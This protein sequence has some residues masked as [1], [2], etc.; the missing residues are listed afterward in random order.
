MK[1]LVGQPG[2]SL[3]SVSTVWGVR[4]GSR[5]GAEHFKVATHPRIN[6]Y[7]RYLSSLAISPKRLVCMVSS[8]ETALLFSRIVTGIAVS[9]LT[10]GRKSETVRCQ[11]LRFCAKN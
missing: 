4:M 5:C 11:L 10:K 7:R 8:L 3:T 1:Q 9:F 2:C 6:R